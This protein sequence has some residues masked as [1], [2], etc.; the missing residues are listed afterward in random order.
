M[1]LSSRHE[2]FVLIGTFVGGLAIGGVFDAFRIFRKNFKIGAS[3]VW[4]QDIVMWSAILTVVYVTLFITN[5]AQ[6]R[7]YEFAGF[8]SGIVLYMVVLSRIVITVFTAI[9][10]FIR[11]I[12]STAITVI[13]FP[14]RLIWKPV[15][16]TGKWLKKHIKRFFD[17]QKRIFS[18][19]YRNF[20]K[21]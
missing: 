3:L 13:L 15:K 4:L 7:W 1:F 11:K 5:D 19:F 18:R 6:L 9:I 17:N 20:K 10:T 21:I 16:A 8:A 14:F 2:L 12:L